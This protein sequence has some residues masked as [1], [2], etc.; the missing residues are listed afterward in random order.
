MK[1]REY[2]IS[3][4]KCWGSNMTKSQS[5]QLAWRICGPGKAQTAYKDKN[6]NSGG[7]TPRAASLGVATLVLSSCAVCVLQRFNNEP[8]CQLLSPS[9]TPSPACALAKE[10]CWKYEMWNIETEGEKKKKNLLVGLWSLF[11][12]VL[13]FKAAKVFVRECCRPFVVLHQCVGS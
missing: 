5:V 1:P 7:N 12:V 9:S 11:V 4:K 2:S 6:K 13:L 8:N 10:I 3:N